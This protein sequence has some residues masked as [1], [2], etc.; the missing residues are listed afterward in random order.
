MSVLTIRKLPEET[1]KRLRL[2]AAANGKS[3]EAEA[4]DILATVLNSGQDFDNSWIG[5]LYHDSISAGGVDLTL[6]P[7]SPATTAE[8]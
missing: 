7:D 3:M 6:P 2:R 8:F 1:K 4:R 5:Q